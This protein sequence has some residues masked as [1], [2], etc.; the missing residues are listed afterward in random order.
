MW[1]FPGELLGLLITEEFVFAFQIGDGDIVLVSRDGVQYAVESEKIL[2]VET[3]SLSS[4]GAWKKSAVSVFPSP[5]QNRLPY[6]YIMSTD[7]MVN[8]HKSQKD[9]EKTCM[10]YYEIAVKYGFGMV[11]SGLEG[12]LSETSRLGCGDD[13]T[14]AMAYFDTDTRLIPNPGLRRRKLRSRGKLSRHSA[15]RWKRRRIRFRK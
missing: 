11:S 5:A 1:V 4:A 10:D 6:M 8:S 13:I 15:G 2:G 14:L 7:G 9:Y 3:Y 12:W